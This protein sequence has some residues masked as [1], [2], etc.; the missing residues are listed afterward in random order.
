MSQYQSGSYQDP[1]G[2]QSQYGQQGQYGQQNQ[3]GQQPYGQSP[4]AQPYDYG[5][6]A[7]QPYD[8]GTPV[9]EKKP[10][11]FGIA[12]FAVVMIGSLLFGWPFQSINLPA[13]VDNPNAANE[14]SLESASLLIV[15]GA[16]VIF[17]GFVLSIVAIAI[18][19]G[20]VWAIVG[21]ILS[22]IM[23]WIFAIVF[24]FLNPTLQSV[25]QR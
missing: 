3:Y 7:A 1:Y 24:M 18:A 13:V 20:R 14:P 8:Y 11:T 4:Y 5:Q 17:V 19:R 21:L 12:S 15:F 22:F 23:P 2:Q 25:L 10:S 9:V 6:Q 16:L